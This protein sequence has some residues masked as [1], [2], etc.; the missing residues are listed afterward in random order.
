MALGT[1]G[2]LTTLILPWQ[3]VSL[4]GNEPTNK[5]YLHSSWYFG[6]YLPSWLLIY[7][8]CYPTPGLALGAAA[9]REGLLG[10]EWCL[11][12]SGSSLLCPHQDVTGAA[13]WDFG[14]CSKW[15]SF[16]GGGGIPIPGGVRG[17]TE[18]GTQCS[19][20]RDRVGIGDRLDSM[21]PEVF[22]NLSDS[23]KNLSI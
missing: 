7:R 2:P 3:G 12:G 4:G 19:G 15:P 17:M 22:S 13:W 9:A 8:R 18:C 6:F 21:T 14:L 16:K 5:S 20:V 10:C 1:P 11:W 23:V